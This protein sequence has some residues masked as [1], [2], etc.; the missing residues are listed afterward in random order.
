M[1]EEGAPVR[2]VAPALELR[3]VG[4]WFAVSG[5]LWYQLVGAAERLVVPWDASF[6]QRPD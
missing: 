2:D 5:I 4:K 3:G 6:R 1:I